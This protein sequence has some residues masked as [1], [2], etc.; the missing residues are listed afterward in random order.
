MFPRRSFAAACWTS[1]A[2]KERKGPMQV[3]LAEEL[4]RIRELEQEREE[5]GA[6]QTPSRQKLRA[7]LVAA[8]AR[9]RAQIARNGELCK[10][11]FHERGRCLR[12]SADL[13]EAERALAIANSEVAAAGSKGGKSYVIGS[14]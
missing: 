8:R 6:D 12:L 10:E 2:P 13:A 7:Q 1:F 4:A 3:L 5:R 11:L 14:A 9:Q